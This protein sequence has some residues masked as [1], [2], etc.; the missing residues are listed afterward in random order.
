MTF[1]GELF[2]GVAALAEF[3]SNEL[4]K[5]VSFFFTLAIFNLFG[6]MRGRRRR[7]EFFEL[8]FADSEV[9]LRV[10]DFLGPPSGFGESSSITS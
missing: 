4:V 7:V 9:R 2:L 8:D 6:K 5:T 10:L 3:L 1:W